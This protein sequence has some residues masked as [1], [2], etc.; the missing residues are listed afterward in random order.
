M[1]ISAWGHQSQTST[2]KLGE[3]EVCSAVIFDGG[4]RYF[5]VGF[6]GEQ[7]PR[8]V[9]PCM[10]GRYKR[11]SVMPGMDARDTFIGNEV[12]DKRGKLTINYPIEHGIITDWDDMEKIWHHAF[13]NVLH[14][15][16]EERPLLVTENINT[17]KSNKEKLIEVMFETFKV[18]ALYVA[19]Q[20]ILSLFSSGRTTGF[21][22]N[23]GDQVTYN[24]AIDGGYILSDAI[25][26]LQVSGWD[27]S[28]YLTKILVDKGY[29]LST[30]AEW[31]MARAIKEK[32]C[33]VALDYAEEMH[34]EESSIE[35]KYELPDGRII[36]VGKER[37]R[38][39]E[40]LFRPSMLGVT[41]PG[42]HKNIYESLAK[43]DFEIRKI[44]YVNTILC[45]GNMLFPGLGERVAKE[46]KAQAPQMTKIKVIV[47]AECRF[48]SWFGGSLLTT[49][50]SFQH[51]WIYNYEYEDFGASIIHRRC[52]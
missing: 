9:F 30:L 24:V 31:E 52:F 28:M 45:G 38:C 37:F 41:S 39:P 8:F 2:E 23:S 16:P 50:N 22:V 46:I 34:T 1:V 43:C 17:P 36:T 48:S 33:Y 15:D 49:L 35:K 32:L 21:V 26:N 6:G 42:L 51:M 14:V 25:M 20:S 19:I 18:P 5:K 13:Y 10:V 29:S 12:T 40:A 11:Q 27:L 47:P 3:G 4:S 7:A 44:F